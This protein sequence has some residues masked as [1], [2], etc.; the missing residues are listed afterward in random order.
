MEATVQRKGFSRNGRHLTPEEKARK[1]RWAGVFLAHMVG[2]SGAEESYIDR[3]LTRVGIRAPRAWLREQLAYLEQQGLVKINHLENGE[4]QA[5]PT[6]YG[7][8]FVDYETTDIPGIARPPDYWGAGES[9]QT[10]APE[11]N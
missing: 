5:T 10:P 8:S 4:W 3:T 1:A 2:E 9:A 6:P 7:S 11:Q